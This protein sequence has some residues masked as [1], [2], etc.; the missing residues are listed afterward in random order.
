MW[1]P[2]SRFLLLV[3]TLLT[4]TG[5][6]H[7]Q[8]ARPD[9]TARTP[10]AADV[11]LLAPGTPSADAKAMAPFDMKDN[12]ELVY[13]L[14]DAGGKPVG[15]LRQRVVRISS[16]QREESKKRKVAES[17][18][19]VKS[20]VY[21]KKKLLR[22]QDLTFRARRDTSFTDGLAETNFGALRSFRDRKLEYE[23]TPLAWPNHPTPGS[24]LAD[25][26]ATIRISS[27]VVSIATVSTT[28]RKRRVVSGPAPLTTPA[29]TFQC[30]KV[31][32]EREDATVPRPDMAMRTSVRQIDYY[33]P[34]IGIIRTEIY[35][36]NC[37]VAQVQ[38][39]AERTPKP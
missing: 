13:R 36:K 25:G 9:T 4:A 37:K 8:V 39:L 26:G 27:S 32:S 34:G 31:E 17:T 20:G 23:A 14:L 5:A 21:E 33:A 10:P 15:E 19:L 12:T 38:E 24:S 11:A 1:F 2:T 6:I 18:A 35:G 3:P 29:G 7:A 16:G 30:Y 28:L 22:L